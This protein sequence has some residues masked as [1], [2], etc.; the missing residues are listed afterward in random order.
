MQIQRTMKSC[1]RTSHIEDIR[2]EVNIK[3]SL[4]Y[5]LYSRIDIDREIPIIVERSVGRRNRLSNLIC[6]RMMMITLSSLLNS[7]YRR[8]SVSR[9]RTTG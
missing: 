4:H 2:N 8:F 7:V 1:T 9:S 3:S 5:A 6:D